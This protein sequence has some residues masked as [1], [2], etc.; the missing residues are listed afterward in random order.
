MHVQHQ[1]NRSFCA[2]VLLPW[3]L[4]KF[5]AISRIKNV[6]LSNFRTFP[7]FSKCKALEDFL[8]SFLETVHLKGCLGGITAKIW[9]FRTDLRFSIFSDIGSFLND[10]DYVI[11]IQDFLQLAITTW[12]TGT[13]GV[14]KTL[15]PFQDK[16]PKYGIASPKNYANYRSMY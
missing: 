13:Q 8:I 14:I 12:D 7:N 11:T 2:L 5:A 6:F 9:I 3:K 15:N 4:L 16:G 1:V 10:I